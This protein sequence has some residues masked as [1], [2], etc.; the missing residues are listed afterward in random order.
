MVFRG[1]LFVT[2]PPPY[3]SA[4]AFMG[5]VGSRGQVRRPARVFHLTAGA[6]VLRK[7]GQVV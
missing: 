5:A 6:L 3:A 2:T 4:H 7:V 1:V